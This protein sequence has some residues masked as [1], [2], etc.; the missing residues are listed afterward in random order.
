MRG[1]KGELHAH[2]EDPPR[3]RANKQR[4]HGT[5]DNDRPPIVGTVGRESGQVRLRMVH[6]TDR[7]TLEAH[8][9]R[10]TLEETSC[11]TDE[12]KSYIISFE[13][14]RPFVMR[15]TN[16]RE[17]MTETAF[18]KSTQTQQKACGRMYGITCAISKAFTKII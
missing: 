3:R 6:N 1:K 11:Y 14:I 18:E 15:N 2:P 10:F 8:V 4:G 13:N 17:T 7:K 9:H 12:W 16:G 5:Y